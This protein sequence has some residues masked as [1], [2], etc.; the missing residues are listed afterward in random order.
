MADIHSGPVAG[1]EAQCGFIIANLCR[2]IGAMPH[3]G[4]KDVIS[5]GIARHTSS[6][7]AKD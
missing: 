4:V 1:G 2:Q 5:V 3:H 6:Q 7:T